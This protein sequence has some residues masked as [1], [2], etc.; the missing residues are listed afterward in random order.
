MRWMTVNPYES[1]KDCAEP[2]DTS[3]K[4][5]KGRLG[6]RAYLPSPCRRGTSG[7]G[8]MPADICAESVFLLR[9]LHR[10]HRILHQ[11]SV[12]GRTCVCQRRHPLLAL[13]GGHPCH[14]NL[15]EHAQLPADPM[16]VALGPF[17]VQCAIDPTHAGV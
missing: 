14:V 1:P 12:W 15:Q 2:L 7:E 13:C 3:P 17:D 10:R 6:L 4:R 11:A 9:S 5:R 16:E 8:G